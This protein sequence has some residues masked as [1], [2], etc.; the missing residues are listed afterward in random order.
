M[1]HLRGPGGVGGAESRSSL[2]RGEH[3]HESAI[4]DDDEEEEGGW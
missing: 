1:S 2:T 3:E 4:D